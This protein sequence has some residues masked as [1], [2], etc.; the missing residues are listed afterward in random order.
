MH[1]PIF[2]H[3]SNSLPQNEF[4]ARAPDE[5]GARTAHSGA[6]SRPRCTTM[7]HRGAAYQAVKSRW[8]FV[9]L[10]LVTIP[11]VVAA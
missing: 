9:V 4:A 3:Q 7:V 2:C 8:L 10:E 11:L 1:G 5:L 6:Y